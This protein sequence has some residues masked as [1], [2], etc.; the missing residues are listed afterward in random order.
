MTNLNIAFMKKKETR[1]KHLSLSCCVFTVLIVL[2]VSHSAALPYVL[3]SLCFCVFV[4][5]MAPLRVCVQRELKKKH[6]MDAWKE[7]AAWE[8]ISTALIIRGIS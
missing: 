5:C 8:M 4:W 3:L 1:K 6:I 2:T 7:E